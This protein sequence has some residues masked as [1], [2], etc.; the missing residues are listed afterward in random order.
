MQPDAWTHVRR[1]SHHDFSA[2][3][4]GQQPLREPGSRLQPLCP[5][6]VTPRAP[7]QLHGGEGGSEHRPGHAVVLEELGDESGGLWAWH[8]VRPHFCVLLVLLLPL[9]LGELQEYLVLLQR[10]LAHR[11]VLHTVLCATCRQLSKEVPQGAA[12]S[13]KQ[14]EAQAATVHLP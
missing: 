11:K 14:L 6:L 5:A 2:F 7:H 9:I 1:A 4:P 13:R 3:P 12:R 8:R 10:G